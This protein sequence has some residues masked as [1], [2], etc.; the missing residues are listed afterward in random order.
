MRAHVLPFPPLFLASFLGQTVP[1]LS[2]TICL[3]NI[4]VQ[5]GATRVTPTA[6]LLA[7]RPLKP[8]IGHPIAPQRHTPL[9]T[10]GRSIAHVLVLLEPLL[11]FP[12]ALPPCCP[13]LYFSGAQDTATALYK[14]GPEPRKFCAQHVEEEGVLA[15]LLCGTASTLLLFTFL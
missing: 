1:L 14:V 11:K 10:P 6:T 15:N 5:N 9:S 12:L 13:C 3:V 2:N 4:V 8:A 7:V